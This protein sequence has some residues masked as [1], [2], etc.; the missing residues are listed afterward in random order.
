MP[1]MNIRRILS[2]SVAIVLTAAP[3]IALAALP[4]SIV[5]QSGPGSC[6]G[7]SCTL[8][9][10]TTLAQNV[11][12]TGIYITV[13]LAAV[14]FAWAGG[15]YLTNNGD[16]HKVHRATETFTNVAVGLIIILSAWLIVS[17]LM[18]VLAGSSSQ[19]PWNKLC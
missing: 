14:L 19:L 17:A 5:P 1:S 15:L 7:A 13:F 11:L 8:C 6:S 3:L 2:V 18:H 10:L 4:D 9:D 16:T 12:N